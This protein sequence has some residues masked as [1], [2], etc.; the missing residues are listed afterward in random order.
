MKHRIVLIGFGTIGADVAAGLRARSDDYTVAALCRRPDT[1]LPDDVH[2][3]RD[4][5]DLLAWRP[6]LVVEVAG[7][8][9]VL[10]HAENCLR[11]GIRF[12][13]TSVGALADDNLKEALAYAA[14]GGKSQLIIPAG[15][16]GSLDYLNA[17]RLVDGAQVTYESRKPAAAWKTELAEL[18]YD[19]AAL[20][21]AVVLYEGDAATAAQKYPKNL[22]V[23]ATLALAGVG[24][25]ATQV[26]VVADPAATENQHTIQVDG[27]MGTLTTRLV[28][29][30]SPGNPKTSWIVAQSVLSA[31]HKQFASVIAA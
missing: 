30:P 26:R 16:V 12:L 10:E 5:L 15:A 27:P 9:A 23:A 7:Q 8:G 11:A 1:P 4:F 28:N 2:R 3:L 18:G 31:I 19:P 24:M 29:R 22:N 13:V 20:A 17:V 21:E 14:R 25:K 6:N